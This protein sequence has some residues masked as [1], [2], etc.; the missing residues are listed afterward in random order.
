MTATKEG[1]REAELE[2]LTYLVNYPDE[3]ADFDASTLG[4]P[5]ADPNVR[6][7]YQAIAELPTPD[8]EATMEAVEKSS[9]ILFSHLCKAAPKHDSLKEALA[10][11]QRYA[12][13]DE[14]TDSNPDQWQPRIVTMSDVTPRSVDWLWYN[15]IAKGRLSL[16][17]GR[18]GLG[19]SFLTCDVAACI[20]TGR[21]FPDGQ[22]CEAGDVL[23]LNAEDDP[24]DTVSPRLLAHEADPTRIHVLQGQ[25]KPGSQ[26]SDLMVSCQ[27]LP[28]IENALKRYPELR[29]VVIDPIGSFLGTGIDAHRDNEVR[30]VLGPIGQLAEKYD[31]AVL[32][33][34]HPNKSVV[35]HADDSIL[36]SRAFTGIVRNVWH[37][38]E[39]HDDD[40]RR[41]LLA[42]KTNLGP[43]MPGLAFTVKP[44]LIQLDDGR[45]IDP[46]RIHWETETVDKTAD[47]H[48]AEASTKKAGDQK[49]SAAEKWLQEF[50]TEPQLQTVIVAAGA[51]QGFK[52]RTL[53]RAAKSLELP[54]TRTD[55]GLWQ[56]EPAADSYLIP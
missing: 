14:L 29:L 40:T 47:E 10:N 21:P 22:P 35:G 46:G 27:D 51:R 53:Q 38:A 36:G 33:V 2:L 7:A 17:A 13:P 39:D 4:K 16:L 8:Y 45:G 24:A 56:W 43:K 52:E 5:F 44:H 20:A 34:A 23:I 3:I 1:R 49:L 42:G 31:V 6:K 28:I 12:D 50:L 55:Q 37:L 15:R 48:F 30:R 18:P 32:I 26:E 9:S 19:K 25:H 11:W 54:K 41:L